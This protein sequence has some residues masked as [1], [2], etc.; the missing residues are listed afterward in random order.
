[1]VFTFK[2]SEVVYKYEEIEASNLEEAI[3]EANRMYENGEV[4]L[5]KDVHVEYDISTVT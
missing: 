2:F 1:M 3:K 4:D 5:M